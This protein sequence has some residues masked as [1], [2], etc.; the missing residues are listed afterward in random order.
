ESDERY[1]H[2][3]PKSA[4]AVLLVEKTGESFAEVREGLQQIAKQTRQ[5][6]LAFDSK[7]ALEHDDVELLC[8]L[9]HRVVPTLYRLKGSTRP[10]PFVEDIAIPPDELSSFL[11]RVQNVLKKHQVTA[12]LFAHAAHGQLH[13]RPFLDLADPEHVRRMQHLARDLY[14]EVLDVKGT[15]SGEHAD[16]LSRTWFVREQYGPLY[17]VF[18]QLKQLF[19]P[20][21]RLNPGKIIDESGQS[22]AQNLRPV[23]IT[24][25]QTELSDSSEPDALIEENETSPNKPIVQ[26]E[27]N[28]T[29]DDM[30]L[31]ARSCNGCGGCRTTSDIERMCPMFRIVPAEEATPR[32]KANLMRAIMTGRLDPE[33]LGSDAISDIADLCFHCHQCRVECPA[34]VDIPK[35]VTEC[36]AQYVA[37]K[38]LPL[39][40]TV[41]SRIDSIA[42]W[43]S[44][45][46]P[47]FNWGIRRRRV[48]WVMEKVLGI[49]QGR[50][51]PP[52]SNRSFLR[53]AARR[54]WT[55]SSRRAGRKVLYFVDVYANW[56]D[57]Q[58]G[59]A[60]VRVFEHNG[61]SVFVHPRQA[62]AGM[63]L[64][65]LGATERAK[66]LARKNVSILADAVRQGYHI[67]A[68]EPAAAMCLTREYVNLLDDEDAVLVAENSSEACAYLWRMHLQGQLQLDMQ[69]SNLTVAYHQPCHAKAMD[70][71]H[72]GENL[73]RLI[74]NLMVQKVER[75]CS[76]MAG[77]FGLKKENYWN[78]LRIGRGLM[79]SLR[80]PDIQVG[81]TEC[82]ACRIQMEQGTN[83]PTVHPIKLLAHAYGL[84]P[85]IGQLLNR[86]S[87]ELVTS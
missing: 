40:D 1:N 43:G 46:S 60:V 20:Q 52:L 50:K 38:G 69:P 83:K 32:A 59:R 63:P 5:K 33:V 61:I 55:R 9:T 23:Q 87:E 65:A 36:K 37:Q 57:T 21:N 35:L 16:G 80:H 3:L 47:L 7:I 10:L 42:A 12:S 81:T 8:R 44:W 2:V 4:E 84:M 29:P 11:V 6:K 67:I 70:D 86:T 78:S 45:I 79:D 54:K 17:D 68:S 15:I 76:G 13:I 58:L 49:A 27:L 71:T 26:L 31:A 64:V 51:L 73:L 14:A 30:T 62:A 85:E 74:P 72:A 24:T 56:F 28:W 48:R 22:L 39:S 19:D 77:T 75:G 18:V 25:S 34:S 53:K 82:S 66:R 41:L